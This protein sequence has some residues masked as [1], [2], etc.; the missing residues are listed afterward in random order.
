MTSTMRV[1]GY[2]AAQESNLPSVGLPRLTG[3][4]DREEDAHLQGF[5]SQCASRC[6]SKRLARHKAHPAPVPLRVASDEG[7]SSW[8]LAVGRRI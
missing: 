7:V 1:Y 3:F 6:A 2:G 8:A 4:E 5:V